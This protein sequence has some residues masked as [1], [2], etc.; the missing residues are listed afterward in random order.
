MH[1]LKNHLYLL[2]QHS[3]SFQIWSTIVMELH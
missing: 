3:D 1:V 2:E